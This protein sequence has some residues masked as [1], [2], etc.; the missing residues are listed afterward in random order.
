MTDAE[1][2]RWKNKQLRHSNPDLK[3]LSDLLFVAKQAVDDWHPATK[4]VLVNAIRSTERW[5]NERMDGDAG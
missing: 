3:C 5:V 4:Q 2:L 1:Y